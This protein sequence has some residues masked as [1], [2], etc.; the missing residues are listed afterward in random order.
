MMTYLLIACSLLTL[1]IAGMIIYY[2]KSQRLKT[3]L[4]L[5]RQELEFKL[6]EKNRYLMER[7]GHFNQLSKEL[8]EARKNLKDSE[9]EKRGFISRISQYQTKQ[10]MTARNHEEKLAMLKKTAADMEVRFENLA[11]KIFE[12]K[13]TLFLAKNKTGLD[14]VIGPFKE[15]LTKLEEK[16]NQVFSQEMRERAGLK[17][18]VKALE[19][20]NDRVFQEVTNLTRA[21]KGDNKKQ[22]NWGEMVLRRLLEESGLEEGRE[23]FVEKSFTREDGGRSRPDVIVKL[24]ENKDIIIDSKVSLKAYESFTRAE[25]DQDRSQAVKDLKLSMTTHIKRLNGKEYDDIEAL[26]SP[27]IVLMFIPNE[28]A[29]LTILREDNAIFETAFSQ[30][31]LIV[32]PST[33]W[34]VLKI[35]DSIWVVQRQ[36]EN[37]HLIVEQA[38]KL[39]EKYRL[40][41][42]ALDLV[43]A[44]VNSLQ[45]A[46][47]K[48]RNRFIS[49][50]GSLAATADK[51]A[52]MGARA[53]GPLPTFSQAERIGSGETSLA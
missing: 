49:G 50:K 35:I 42:E 39:M 46:Y 1:A 32:G 34:A 28:S 52:E 12:E 7:A 16:I 2:I 30:R 33:L 45:T 5:V 27:G 21:L 26:N 48:A 6:E 8:E 15:N 47:T 18:N 10:E 38:N 19:D 41:I 9:E 20:L 44:R 4:G 23:F 53:K 24:P 51:L 17:E 22:G 31:I 3:E 37:T 43:G 14:G 11:N 29:Y 25:S 13:N 36:N 40:F